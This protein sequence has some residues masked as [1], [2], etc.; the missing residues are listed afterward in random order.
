[1][2]RRRSER[3]SE[4]GRLFRGKLRELA[5][6]KRAT[7]EDGGSG[8]VWREGAPVSKRS[9]HLRVMTLCSRQ[10]RWRNC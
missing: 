2:A 9:S 3:L 4:I 6:P 1:M 7:N 8:R 5:K 10:P